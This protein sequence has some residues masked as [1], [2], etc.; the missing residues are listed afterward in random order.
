MESSYSNQAEGYLNR[1]TEWQA[2]RIKRA[3]G[4]LPA[5]DVRKL[6]GIDNAYWLRVG[7]V[8]ILFE[9]DGN[10]IN[11][12]KIDNRGDVYK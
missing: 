11:V 12:I 5:G 2:A 4:K 10:N 3:V 7:G 9:K 6:K 8:R 1:Q